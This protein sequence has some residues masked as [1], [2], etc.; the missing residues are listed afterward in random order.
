MATLL[1]PIHILLVEDSASDAELT[2]DALGASRVVNEVH[3]VCDGLE[4]LDFLHQRGPYRRVPR[5]HLILLDLNLPRMNGYELL[6]EIK[7]VD[8]LALIPVVVLTTS[9]SEH[10]IVRSYQLRAN[11]YVSKPVAL[12]EFLAVVKDTGN[13]WLERAQLPPT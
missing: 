9:S 10:D 2:M 8:E 11:C 12:D 7:V 3:R 6:G 4:A 1:E 5:P 13:F